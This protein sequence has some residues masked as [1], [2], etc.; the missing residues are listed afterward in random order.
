[1]ILLSKVGLF[2]TYPESRPGCALL[3][4]ILSRYLCTYKLGANHQFSWLVGLLRQKSSW[5]MPQDIERVLPDTTD[6]EVAVNQVKRLDKQ[7]ER[8]KVVVADSLSG[9]GHGRAK[10]YRPQPQK[11]HPVGRK[12]PQRVKQ[13]VKQRKIAV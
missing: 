8:L 10:G 7:S 1:M 6:S 12:S 4:E 3:H 5:V 9:K 2:Y 11:R 13:D